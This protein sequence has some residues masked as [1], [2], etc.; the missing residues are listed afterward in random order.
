MPWWG[1]VLIGLAVWCIAAV[2]I[3]LGLGK[4]LPKTPNEEDVIAQEVAE[5]NRRDR[6]NSGNGYDA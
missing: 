2:P 6:R 1:W 5:A 3:S 4:A